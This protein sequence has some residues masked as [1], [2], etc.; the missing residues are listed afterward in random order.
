MVLTDGLTVI[1]A[2]ESINVPPQLSVYQYQFVASPKSGL[3]RESTVDSP[4]HIVNW[5]KTTGILG[6]LQ[7]PCALAFKLKIAII[8]KVNTSLNWMNFA[9]I[10]ILK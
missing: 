6:S 4:M 2:P 1:I 7:G 10:L 9:F 8:S 3:S 5:P